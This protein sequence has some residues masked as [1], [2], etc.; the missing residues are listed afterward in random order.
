VANYAASRVLASPSLPSL[1]TAGPAGPAT[2]GGVSK[3]IVLRA[4]ARNADRRRNLYVMKQPLKN[5]DRAR[6]ARGWRQSGQTQPQYAAKH[7]IRDRTLRMWIARW[8]P[9]CATDT[10]GVRE[11]VERAIARLRALADG[12]AEERTGPPSAGGTTNGAGPSS[13]TIR[14]EPHGSTE[15]ATSRPAGFDLSNLGL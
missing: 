11:V 10:K 9:P 13:Q 5:E 12:L 4:P 6:I 2:P 15:P 8:A 7:Q 1:L 14:P 3:E